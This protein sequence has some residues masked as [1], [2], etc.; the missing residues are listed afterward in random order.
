M[1]RA[2]ASGTRGSPESRSQLSPAVGVLLEAVREL[3]GVI[4]GLGCSRE[5]RK[6]VR[7]AKEWRQPNA[8][9]GIEPFGRLGLAIMALL[10]AGPR[11]VST[12]ALALGTDVA[13]VSHHLSALA[14]CGLV[15]SASDRNRHVQALSP[16]I[17]V[18]R[19]GGDCQLIATFGSVVLASLSI[20][21]D[22]LDRV[23]DELDH[24]ER[25]SG[26]GGVVHVTPAHIHAMARKIERSF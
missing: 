20:Q 3:D 12:L 17:Q 14:Q 18:R 25:F 24:P 5:F 19:S 1:K 10:A 21:G 16:R 8:H 9:S 22:L 23:R 13:K 7:H 11:D 2:T 26:N 6:S 15:L 4:H